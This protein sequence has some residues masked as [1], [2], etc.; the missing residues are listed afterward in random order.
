MLAGA[1]TLKLFHF[2]AA[3]LSWMAPLWPRPL[4]ANIDWTFGFPEQK[5]VTGAYFIIFLRQGLSTIELESLSSALILYVL[6]L[7]PIQCACCPNILNWPQWFH[8]SCSLAEIDLQQR[9]PLFHSRGKDCLSLLFC[10]VLLK[11]RYWPCGPG[12]D[13][14]APVLALYVILVV[15]ALVLASKPSDHL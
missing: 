3:S 6:I 4:T 10:A 5:G 9:S 15:S 1:F 14:V 2:Q 8:I 12:T 11:P 7:R 13:P